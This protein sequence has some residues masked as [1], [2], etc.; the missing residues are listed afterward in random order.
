M[1][2]HIFLLI[3]LVMPSLSWGGLADIS[4]GCTN[5]RRGPQGILGDPGATGPT[6]PR[7]P[8]GPTGPTGQTGLRGPDGPTGPSG[9]T[10]IIGPTGISPPGPTG[11]MGPT[12]PVGPTGATGAAATVFDF[13][14]VFTLM[15]Q[16]IATGGYL[17]T[18][19][20]NTTPFFPNGSISHVPPSATLT[21]NTTGVY[22][23]VY[24]TISNA[25]TNAL[26]LLRNGAPVPGSSTGQ[27][28]NLPPAPFIGSE[29]IVALNAG[30]VLSLEI[31]TTTPGSS[32]F[33]ANGS[34]SASMTILR[35]R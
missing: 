16:S 6:G 18:F 29:A 34:C 19:E 24:M 7:G 27:N 13:G 17:V 12:G 26:I 1:M 2:K 15:T 8:T 20:N 11:A 5:C 31:V 4:A 28:N 22:H 9:P 21:V 33:V 35:L 25:T 10:G 3:T 30:D 14:G 32:L 23:I